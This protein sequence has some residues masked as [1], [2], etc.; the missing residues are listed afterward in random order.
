MSFS[1]GSSLYDHVKVIFKNILKV[2]NLIFEK[3]KLF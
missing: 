1:I 2:K 3:N